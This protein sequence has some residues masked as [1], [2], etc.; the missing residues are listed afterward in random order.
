MKRRILVA[1]AAM[2]ACAAYG[3][4]AANAGVGITC[5]TLLQASA[6]LSGDI[7][8]CPDH[9]III[10]ADGITLDLNGHRIFG[11]GSGNGSGV[12]S[13]GHSNVT[14]TSSASGGAIEQFNNGILMSQGGS[15]TVSH[16]D[17][18]DNFGSA[19]SGGYGV[20]IDRESGDLVSRNRILRDGPFGGI[21]IFGDVAGN[22]VVHNTL[23]RNKGEDGGV[24]PIGIQLGT[25]V[26]DTLVKNNRVSRTGFDGISAN[27]GHNRIFGNTII[28]SGVTNPD[29]NG[30]YFNNLA[31]RSKILDNVIQDSA[32]NGIY[33]FA[34]A[35]RNTISGNAV[36]GSG[37]FD[38]LD[39]NVDCDHN[40]WISNTFGTAD[41]ACAGG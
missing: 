7:G 20:E 40:I 35:T 9:G 27:S 29:G 13:G 19:G 33:V 6:T 23:R 8:P 18:R 38:L 17:V 15:N 16:L 2:G 37:G 5:G 11:D 41:P 26:H 25:F 4:S 28:D 22:E 14:V 30:I 3:A 31:H 1:A 10:G 34:G 32:N 12:I 36:A 24:T 39:A 21:G